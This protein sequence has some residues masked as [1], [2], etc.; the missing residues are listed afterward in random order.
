MGRSKRG[1][2][3]LVCGGPVIDRRRGSS[4]AR[5]AGFERA[6]RFALCLA[7]LG[8]SIQERQLRLFAK[9]DQ[10]LQVARRLARLQFLDHWPKAEADVN[11]GGGGQASGTSW[12][13]LLWAKGGRIRAEWAPDFNK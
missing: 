10:P 9:G 11:L 1:V 13:A 3:R 4:A 8:A 12:A 5:A 2:G 6:D 7:R